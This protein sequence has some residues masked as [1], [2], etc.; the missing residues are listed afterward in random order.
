MY[1]IYTILLWLIWPFLIVYHLY[2]SISRGRPPAL[3]QRFGFDI[4]AAIAILRGRRPI[5]IHAVS[6]GETIAVKPLISALRLRYPDIP[7]LLSTMTE[8]GR[9]LAQKI[10]EIDCCLYFPFDYRLATNRLL[11]KINPLAVIIAETELWPNFIRSAKKLDIPTIIV[12]GRISDRSFSR[13]LRLGRFFRPVL[14]DMFALCMQGSEDARRIVA[15]GANS[16]RVF[17]TRNLK[18]DLLTKTLAADELQTVRAAFRLVSDC[19]I[20]TAGSTHSGEEE[21]ILDAF[22]RIL[23]KGH[24]ALLVLVPRH[25]ERAAEVAGLLVRRGFTFLRR[26]QLKEDSPV[27]AAGEVLLVDTI[28]EL[29][30]L[31]AVADIV[32]VGGSLVPCGGH[33][34]LEPASLGRPVLFGEHVA[35]FREIAS[36]AL[37]YGAASQVGN[38]TELAELCCTLLN[39]HEKLQFMGDNGR[40]LLQEQG[41]ATALNM[42]VIERILQ[43]QYP[44]DI[45]T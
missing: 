9:G 35:N 41:G 12:N 18:F 17:V 27:I 23:A 30:N 43:S 20:I 40:R 32:F 26:S 4:T 24:K 16:A 22:A 44:R 29:M 45:N 5:W 11:Q 6:V 1:L 15:I 31:Y 37:S 39:D 34:L 38:S 25:P 10:T 33:N 42:A 19:R 3:L 8:T 14:A 13:Y 36:L 7:L 28:G 21:Q 2:R